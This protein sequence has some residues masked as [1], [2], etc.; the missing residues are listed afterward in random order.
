MS[1]VLCFLVVL[2]RIADSVLAFVCFSGSTYIAP[3][4]TLHATL[5]ARLAK[6]ESEPE[7]ECVIC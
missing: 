2:E 4:E 3:D 5:E 7:S 1:G 6:P